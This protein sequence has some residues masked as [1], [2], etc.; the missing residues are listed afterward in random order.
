MHILPISIL[1]LI[2]SDMVRYRFKSRRDLS[3]LLGKFRDAFRVMEDQWTLECLNGVSF[4]EIE[5]EEVTASHVT[6]RHQK[7]RSRISLSNL[8]P[9]S[10]ARLSAGFLGD[11]S[12]AAAPPEPGSRFSQA[13]G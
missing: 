5:I 7:G 10:L 1:R 13:H 4:E 12:P 6:F 2:A 9:E 3:G 8:S 11:V